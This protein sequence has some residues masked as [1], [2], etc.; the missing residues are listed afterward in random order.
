M[1]QKEKEILDRGNWSGRLDFI[2]S[3]IGFSVGLGNVWRF[4]YLCYR[5]G[6]G[7][8]LIPYA[9]MLVIAGIP[10]YFFELSFGQFA[11][12]G[13]ITVWTVSPFFMGVG[14]AM[15]LISAMVC[16]YY[17]VIIMYSVYYMMVSFVTMDGDLP[18]QH[19]D[20]EWASDL[21]REK[22]YPKFDSMTNET[23]KI[24]S[25]MELK[26]T[27]CLTGLLANLS[28]SF[29][30][31][32]NTYNDLNSSILIENTTACDKDLKLPSEEYFERYVLRL[33]EA[34]GFGDFGGVSLKLVI[35]LLLTWVV[36]FFCLMKGIK[37][38]GKVVYFTATFPYIVLVILLIRG[39]TLEGFEKGIEFY[40]VPDWQKLKDPKV[41]GDAATQIFYSLGVA[42]GGLLTMS[43][44]NRFKNNTIRDAFLVTLINCC[45][46]VFAGFAVFSL[47]GFM[48]HTLN[49]DVKDVV[50][51]G[52]GLA[53]IAYPE[54]IARMPAAPAFFSFLFFFM[55]FTLGLDSQFAMME[56]VIS[57]FIDAFPVFL[58][59]KKT[60][61]TFILCVIGFLLGMPQV[62]KGGIYLLTLIDW[63]SG[64]YNLMIVS[65]CELVGICYVYGINNFRHDIEMMVGIQHPAFW[66]YWYITWMFITPV[67]IIFIVIMS[68]LNYAPAY[69]GDYV[70][71]GYAEALGWLM[72]CSPLALIVLGF[73]VQSIRYGFPGAL[74]KQPEWGPALDEDRDQDPRKRYDRINELRHRTI[75]SNGK[76]NLAYVGD[77]KVK[78]IPTDQI[79][80]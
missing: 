24:K 37:S 40:M 38:S 78:Y 5:N 50:D 54:G 23:D 22:P 67:A 1:G 52:P 58:R 66:I 26:D 69:Y 16:T 49:R 68:G 80:L 30:V 74:K 72:V 14:W 45:T 32:Y 10:L 29:S 57:G 64:S 13:P 55:I 39:L 76:D 44:Y 59:P 53:F 70:F 61:F 7:A 43:S 42:F 3:C 63:Y 79:R 47:L 36:I 51:S 34:N 18:W 19:C 62:C 20:H 48:A 31:T 2:L 71:P 9:I 33:H 21:C 15:V 6:G 17:N 27:S 4:P 41:W 8:F 12:Q 73:I 60:L 77:K 28:A 35:C 25:A 46:S 75:A 56:T 65:L 11:S